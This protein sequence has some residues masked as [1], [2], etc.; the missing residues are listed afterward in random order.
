MYLPYPAQTPA[1]GDASSTCSEVSSPSLPQPVP[2]TH[3]ANTRQTKTSSTSGNWEMLSD[4]GASFVSPS[5]AAKQDTMDI[6]RSWKS[7]RNGEK[8]DDFGGTS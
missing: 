1:P 2:A 5:K 8:M 6:I 3:D 7:S 4:S